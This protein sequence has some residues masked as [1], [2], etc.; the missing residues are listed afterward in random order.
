M[1]KYIYIPTKIEKKLKRLEVTKFLDSTLEHFS[2]A[3]T[4]RRIKV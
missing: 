1:E 3:V 2:G 4:S